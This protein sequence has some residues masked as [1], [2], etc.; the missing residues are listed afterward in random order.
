MVK[1]VNEVPAA[2]RGRKEDPAIS[3]AVEALKAKPGAWGIVLEKVSSTDANRFSRNLTKTEGVE[4]TVR[5]D[6]ETY[7]VYASYTAAK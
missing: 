5:G 1:F 4:A 2:K 3:A 6:G 7:T